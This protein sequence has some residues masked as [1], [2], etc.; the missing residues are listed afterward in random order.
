[1]ITFPRSLKGYQGAK[2][3]IKIRIAKIFNKFHYFIM[4]FKLKKVLD[5]SQITI[6]IW[7]KNALQKLQ[8]LFQNIKF[9]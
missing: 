2:M 8:N 1:M 5:K 9:L 7:D 6:I 3:A 4:F